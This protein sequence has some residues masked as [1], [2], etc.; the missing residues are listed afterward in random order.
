MKHID[1]WLDT[2]TF[3]SEDNGEIYAKFVLDYKRLPAWKQNAYAE[4]M[5]QFNL[6][7]TYEGKRYK[8]SGASRLGD[9]WLTADFT[10]ELG[11]DLR[12]DVMGIT[13]WSDKP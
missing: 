10:K 11:Y 3:P 8:C 5:S 7:C 1:D 2:P 13:A 9:V 12:V 4:W 6:Y